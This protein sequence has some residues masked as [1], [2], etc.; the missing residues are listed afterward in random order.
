[1]NPKWTMLKFPQQISLCLWEVARSFLQR[2]HH[3]DSPPAS[4]AAAE[5][6]TES[7]APRE[8]LKLSHLHLGPIE[9]QL[10]LPGKKWKMKKGSR[11]QGAKTPPK[12][13]PNGK[14]L[15]NCPETRVLCTE[16][17]DRCQGTSHWRPFRAWHFWRCKARP[18]KRDRDA[19]AS[20]TLN[21]GDSGGQLIIFQ[22]HFPHAPWR[23]YVP[24]FMIIDLDSSPSWARNTLT[25]WLWHGRAFLKY[26]WR[27]KFQQNSW[28]GR[29]LYTRPGP[30]FWGTWI[31]VIN[32]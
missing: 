28:A 7:Q 8:L 20:R 18:E 15:P 9:I 29:N 17:Q 21:A 24:R 14:A 2:L 5:T 19:L 13:V 23:V 25:L 16:T 27:R 1:M 11:G 4:V 6:T 10:V 30:L 12:A 26:L 3:H 22:S 32:I 31:G